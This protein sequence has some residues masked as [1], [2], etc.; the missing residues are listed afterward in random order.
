[1]HKHVDTVWKNYKKNLLLVFQQNMLI[2]YEISLR[3]LTNYMG[4]CHNETISYKI[5]SKWMNLIEPIH[6]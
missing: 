5:S 2:S 1:M 3:K 4:H 6:A